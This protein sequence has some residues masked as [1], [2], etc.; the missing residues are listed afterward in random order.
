MYIHYT[1]SI[2]VHQCTLT[3]PTWHHMYYYYSSD[4][5]CTNY[6]VMQKIWKKA[7]AKALK[8]YCTRYYTT[9][10][11]TL[12]TE[13]AHNYHRVSDTCTTELLALWW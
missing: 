1:C 5:S 9:L 6:G 3:Q 10:S 11:V 12:A 7:P 8:T 2:H 13:L 4:K